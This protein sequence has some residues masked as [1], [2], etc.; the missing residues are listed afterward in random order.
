[1]LDK[2]AR[3][4]FNGFF[5][6][7]STIS[8][9]VHDQFFEIGT[10]FHTGI[11]NRVFNV[12]DWG[13]NKTDKKALDISKEIVTSDKETFELNNKMIL[14]EQDYEI[15]KMEQLLLS[16]GEIIQIRE[17]IIKSSDAQLKNGVITASEYLVELTNL[18]EAKNIL[19]THEVQLA[20]TKS[21]YEIIKGK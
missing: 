21:N 8:N 2:D 17:K 10:L 1:M 3:C 4:F 19:K 15:K 6:V 7:N 9:Y 13:K 5:W 14:E 18:F 11:F 12:F 20:A 16:D